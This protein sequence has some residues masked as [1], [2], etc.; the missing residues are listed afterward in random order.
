MSMDDVDSEDLEALFDSIVS[1]GEPA[2]AAPAA[3]DAVDASPETPSPESDETEEGSS[4]NEKVFSQIGHLTRKLHS[5]LQELGY[6]KALEHAIESMPDTRDRLQYIAAMTEQA[7]DRVLNATEVARPLQ[8]TL[9]SEA[10][11]L[12]GQWEKLY[13]NEL[14]VEQFKQL[15]GTTRQFLSG[16]A[17]TTRATNTQL[18]EIM[19]AQDFQDLTGQVIKK[20]IEVAQCIEQQMVQLLL[21]TTPASKREHAHSEL[22][23]GPVIKPDGR[24]DIVTE[25][26]QVDELLESLG[27]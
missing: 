13:R 4:C 10:V 21:E 8:E 3:Q 19:M 9:E 18:T 16:V 24:S 12:S 20:V 7:A 11:S 22:L 25:Q 15:A 27:F 23:N 1:A 26:G 14:D 17:E 5:T 2:V 6:D